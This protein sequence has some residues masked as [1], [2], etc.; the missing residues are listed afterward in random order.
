MHLHHAH[1]QQENQT[2]A[3]LLFDFKLGTPTNHSVMWQQSRKHVI[4]A[5]CL[6]LTAFTLHIPGILFS[7]L[8]FAAESEIL[9]VWTD[10]IKLRCRSS[11]KNDENKLNKRVKPTLGGLQGINKCRLKHWTWICRRPEMTW[12][13]WFRKTFWLSEAKR[14]R[15]T[16]HH[17]QSQW[18]SSITSNNN[19]NK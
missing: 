7:L 12:L 17:Y 1:S 19:N 13:F 10:W 3:R 2:K 18:G 8:S 15:S 4:F 5:H 14:V 11:D 9:R 16:N 6:L